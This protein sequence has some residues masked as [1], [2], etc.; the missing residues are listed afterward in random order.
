MFL[1]NSGTRQEI[2]LFDIILDVNKFIKAL[3]KQK[4]YKIGKSVSK[5]TQ[6]LIYMIASGKE[7]Y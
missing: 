3:E 2:L 6:L 7:N 5:I 1:L 4:I